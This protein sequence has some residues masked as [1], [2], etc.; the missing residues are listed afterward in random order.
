M[1]FLFGGGCVSRAGRGYIVPLLAP[2]CLC[3]FFLL[4]C[5]RLLAYMFIHVWLLLE[6]SFATVMVRTPQWNVCNNN[7]YFYIYIYITPYYVIKTYILLWQF[8]SVS[9]PWR[10]SPPPSLPLPACVLFL[11]ACAALQVGYHIHHVLE[12]GL[13]GSLHK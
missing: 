5:F 13:S 3:A 6:F 2:P 9:F 11:V 4:P 10:A 8:L 7:I 1:L 12:R